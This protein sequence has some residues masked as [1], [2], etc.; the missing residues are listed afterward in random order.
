MLVAAG[1]PGAVEQDDLIVTPADA[2]AAVAVAGRWRDYAL[3]FGA[4]IGETLLE[5]HIARALR[6][7]DAKNGRCPRRVIAQYVHCSKKVLD[8]IEDTLIDRGEITLEEPR[9]SSGPS[10]TIWVRVKPA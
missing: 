6:V 9:G 10:T 2:E 5:Q 3:A 1:R 7:L 4:Q 8:E